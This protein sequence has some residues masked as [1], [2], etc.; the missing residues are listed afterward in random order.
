MTVA[1]VSRDGTGI[2]WATP[3]YT[4][5]DGDCDFFWLSDRHSAH[6]VN[7]RNN[8]DVGLVTF[9]STVPEGTGAGGGVY[10]QARARELSAPDEARRAEECL[11]AR[12]GRPVRPL[13]GRSGQS[14]ARFY[15]AR[16][17]RMWVNDSLLRDGV[18]VDGRT[19]VDL[20]ALRET[21]RAASARLRGHG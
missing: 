2:P 8:P 15:V 19:E 18:R 16:P 3:V 11:T 10:I 17:T 1:T 14:P 20:D 5:F 21:E 12:A 7:I 13:A 9:D 6:S 4:A